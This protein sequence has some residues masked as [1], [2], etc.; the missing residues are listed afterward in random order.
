MNPF[1]SPTC[2]LAGTGN[3]DL[4]FS[5]P[6]IGPF[7][8][9][10]AKNQIGFSINPFTIRDESKW[11]CLWIYFIQQTRH[12][13]NFLILSER[14]TEDHYENR[15]VPSGYREKYEEMIWGSSHYE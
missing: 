11:V 13:M 14:R 2:I 9:G 7:G 3:Q 1:A 8:R 6:A 12:T 4:V 15:L 5:R 10:E